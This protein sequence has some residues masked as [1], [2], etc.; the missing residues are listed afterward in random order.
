MMGDSRLYVSIG[1]CGLAAGGKET[2]EKLKSALSNVVEVV[3]AG[4]M[5]LCYAEPTVAFGSYIFGEV[6]GEKIDA[7]IDFV[8]KGGEPPFEPLSVDGSAYE[9]Q[10]RLVLRNCGY[11][12]PEEIDDYIAHGG[13]TA[14]K[15][16]LLEKKP[17]E[18]IEIIKASGLRGR[19]GAGFPT[20]VKWEI[21]ASQ[22]ADEKFVVCNADEGDPGAYMDRA[23]LEGDP[24]S[25]IEAMII[26]GHCIGARKGYIYV[27]AEYP[28]AVERLQR[29]IAQAREKGFLGE[30]ILKTDFSF[31]IELRLGAGAF[32]CGEETALIASIE[33]KRGIPRPKPPYPAEKGLWGKPTLINNV[34]TFANIPWIINNGAEKFAEIGTER[35]RGTK[36][37]SVTGKAARAGLVEVPMGTTI[38]ELVYDIA[39]GSNSGKRVKAVQT[40]GPS[41]GVIPYWKFDVPIDYES[42][43]SL[44]AIMGSGGLIVLDEDDCMVDVARYFL[45]FTQAES[46]GQC[47]PCREG[48]FRMLEILERITQG[49]GT[50]KDFEILEYLA[51]NIQR[52][53]L[54]GLGKTAPNPVLSTI[55]WFRDEY[56]AHIE[57]GEC[58]AGVCRALI[59]YVID[60]D[61]C[62]GCSLC[63]RICPVGA[64]HGSPRKL[65]VINQ[66]AC[67]KCGSCLEVC[68]FG[69]VK[70][71]SAAALKEM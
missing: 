40:G 22:K 57:R 64:I 50:T 23:V 24:H 55:R 58:P 18:V 11:M 47:T 3:P 6:T 13:Y 8:K 20:G 59:V 5:G 16:V 21:V 56:I 10:L 19:G 45:T 7:I 54:C 41:G 65:Y 28:L 44:G 48:T 33:G 4:C 68:R 30:R 63:A 53:A 51:R 36:I 15:T 61:L 43:Q 37:F 17:E 26:A 25:V 71:K 27:R 12:N 38:K 35:S 70:K 34:E 66:E 46:C 2:Y 29:A 9:K 69:A 60:P 67:I 39:G 1:S 62:R 32:V 31:D 42:L 49:K 52:T 14:L